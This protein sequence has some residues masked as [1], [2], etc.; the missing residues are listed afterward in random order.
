MGKTQKQHNKPIQKTQHYK[1]NT[2]KTR[3]HSQTLRNQHTAKPTQVNK[4]LRK[5]NPKRETLDQ[6]NKMRVTSSLSLQTH[7]QP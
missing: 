3:A 5:S 7:L 2:F 4:K 6:S 1:P